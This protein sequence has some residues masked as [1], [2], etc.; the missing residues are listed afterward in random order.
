ME[1]DWEMEIGGE[2]PVIDGCWEGFVD[3]RSD[4]SRVA[5]ISEGS[6]LPGLAPAL[7]R[8]NG[9]LSGVWTSKCDVW[10]VEEFDPCELD[11]D[12]GSVACAMAAYIDMLP[13][14][15]RH[16][17]SPPLAERC[18]RQMCTALR[19]IQLRKCRA[20][21]VVRRAFITPDRPGLGITLYVTACGSSR[22]D[23]LGMLSAALPEVVEVIA[24]SR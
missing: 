24:R 19:S 1:A 17:A 9:P 13:R 21:F 23:A 7:N 4:A 8:L 18:C 22:S 16:W 6:Q 3:L 14:S 2:S 11:A 20:D 5:E 12:E 15:G 10:N